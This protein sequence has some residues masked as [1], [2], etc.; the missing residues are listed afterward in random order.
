MPAGSCFSMSGK[1]LRTLLMTVSGLE[2]GVVNTPTNTAFSPSNTEDESAFSAPSSMVAMSFRRISASPRDI[3]TSLPNS[4]GVL[5][6]VSALMV[7]CTKSPFTW[8]AALV[9]LLVASALRTSS[10]VTPSA[11][12]LSGLSQMRMANVCPPRICAL[13]TPSMVC[14]RGCT[15]RVR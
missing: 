9:K 6:A 12:I 15:T 13:A 1:A 4:T 3:T 8:P 2:V 11:A 10:G 7:V 5:S 14:R